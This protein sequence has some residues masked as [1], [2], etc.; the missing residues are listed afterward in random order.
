MSDSDPARQRPVSSVPAAGIVAMGDI[1]VALRAGVADFLA[2]P[3]FGLFFGGIC[4]IGGLLILSSLTVLDAKWMMI[5]IAVGF[6]LVGPFIAV[7]LYEVSRR[8]AAGLPLDWGDILTV[9]FH[10]RERQFAYSGIIVM[11]IFWVWIFIAR[12]VFAIFFGGQSLSGLMQ[13]LEQATTTANGLVFLLVGTAFGAVLALVLFSAT[14]V[15]LPMLVDRDVDLI[16]AVITS[17]N[18]VAN[19]P[20]A[21]LAWAAIITVGVV[22]AMIPFFVGLIVVLP[23]LGH[24]TWHLYVRSRRNIGEQT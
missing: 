16:S 6:P 18:T 24:A 20:T 8:R 3:L 10:Q 9:I 7:G 23:V 14:V 21:M 15:S 4:A 22:A 11:C 12:I 17:F 19:N 5:P 1:S 13:F 2:A